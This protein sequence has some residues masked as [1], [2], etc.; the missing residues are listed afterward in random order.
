MPDQ[1]KPA[2][3]TDQIEKWWDQNP[4][5]WGLSDK[6]ADLV[7]R[8]D[9]ASMD[10]RYFEEVERKFRKHTRG[11]SQA[12][13]APLLSAYVD[14]DWLGGKQALDIAV[15]SGFSMVALIQGGAQVT[16]IDL[17]DFAVVQTKRNLE[18]RGMQGIVQKM[19][20]QHMTFADRSFDFVDAWGC[21]MHM[22][23]TQGAINEIYRVLRPD[24]RVL[25][26]MYNKSSWPFWF[27]LIFLRGIL[28]GKL[29]TYRFNIDKL[30]SRYSDGFSVGGNMLAKFYTPAGAAAMFIKAGF[31][32]VEALPFILDDEVDGWPMARFPI[33]KYLPHGIKRRMARWSYGLIIKAEK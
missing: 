33:F 21:L 11:G 31:S 19:D 26:Y 9:P 20:A 24:G 22:P 10:M 23:D 6:S 1:K 28:Q 5:T 15:G 4:F 16:G 25:A 32:K 2:S 30:T 29:I 8:V 13:G 3:A 27:N 7:G 14:Y 17:T 12:D 18:L